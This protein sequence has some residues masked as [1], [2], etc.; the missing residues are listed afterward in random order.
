M[1]EGEQQGPVLVGTFFNGLRLG[2]WLKM[3]DPQVRVLRQ[4]NRGCAGARL[5]ARK[6]RICKRAFARPKMEDPQVRDRPP[7]NGGSA[8]PRSPARKRRSRRCAFAGSKMQ[9]PRVRIRP[10]EN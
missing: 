3:K 4:K 1:V 2:I 6:W 8:G 7:G 10:P 5:P 9:D